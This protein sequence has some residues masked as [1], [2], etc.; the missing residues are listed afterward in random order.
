MDETYEFEITEDFLEAFGAHALLGA[1]VDKFDEVPKKLTLVFP[2]TGIR[3]RK[4]NG[5]KDYIMP[6]YV[7]M[8][9]IRDLL[10]LVRRG[11]EIKLVERLYHPPDS[12]V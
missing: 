5:P 11:V 8:C 2:Q 1:L 12:E 3:W 9:L 4:E 7:P 6:E 10:A